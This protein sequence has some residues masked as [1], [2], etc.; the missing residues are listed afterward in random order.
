MIIRARMII[1]SLS[2]VPYIGL[3]KNILPDVYR[4]L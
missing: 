1:L 4:M 3:T 2:I